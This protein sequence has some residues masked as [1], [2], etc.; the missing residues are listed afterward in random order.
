MQFTKESAIEAAKKDCSAR[1]LSDPEDIFVTRVID[2]EFP[3]SAL[4]AAVKGEMSGMMM[5]DGWRIELE[6]NDA[7]FEY[8]ANESQLRLYNYQGE[9]FVIG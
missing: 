8:R 4:G 3:N 6:A 9:N 7:A 2:T 5:T 1:S